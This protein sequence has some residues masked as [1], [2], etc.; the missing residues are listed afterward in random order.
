[1]SDDSIQEPFEDLLENLIDP[2]QPLRASLIY[3]LSDPDPV[4]ML[5]FQAIW[6]EVPVERKRLLLTR[7]GTGAEEGQGNNEKKRA[8]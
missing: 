4:E 5:A 8:D 1:M 3:R 7:T 6:E 2:E